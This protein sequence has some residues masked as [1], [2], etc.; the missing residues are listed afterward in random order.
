MNNLFEIQTYL[1]H[2][3]SLLIMLTTAFILVV[4]VLGQILSNRTSIPAIIF[5][6]VLV[7]F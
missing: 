3:P 5:I 1:E 4:G 7:L 6:W 2:Y